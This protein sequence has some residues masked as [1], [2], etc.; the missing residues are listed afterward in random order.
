MT[1][2]PIEPLGGADPAATAEALDQDWRRACRLDPDL[3][4]S[5]DAASDLAYALWRVIR[6]DDPEL[7]TRLSAAATDFVAGHTIG[8]LAVV[9]RELLHLT[10]QG[11]EQVGTTDVAAALKMERRS[12]RAQAVLV[13]S[14]ADAAPDWKELSERDELTGL[15]N[16]RGFDRDVAGAIF[17]AKE[18]DRSCSIVLIDL[19]GLKAIND[20][21]GHEAGD[22]ILKTAAA[23]L[24]TS[25]GVGGSAYRWGGDEYAL[26]LSGSTGLQA[27]SV[28]KRVEDR[29]D[30][31]AMSW[32]VGV[33]PHDGVGAAEV[34]AAA[35]RA[36]YAMKDAHHGRS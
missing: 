19:D 35:D 23:V 4:R 7:A 1:E 21:D 33:Y 29:G 36:M 16:R 9:L 30:A 25:I 12:R 24:G 32:G 3:G 28:M 20:Q 14:A 26:V 31:P 34:V 18:D 5:P 11:S 13:L 8:T 22:A 15:R 2:L 27:R 6:S 17:A 10:E